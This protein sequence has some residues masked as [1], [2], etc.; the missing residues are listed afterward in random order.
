MKNIYFFIQ[1]LARR[2]SCHMKVTDCCIKSN[3]LGFLAFSFIWIN[4]SLK[5]EVTLNDVVEVKWRKEAYRGG[6][7]AGDGQ[8][9]GVLTGIR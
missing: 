5:V 4:T 2:F 8:M 7:V 1:S 6:S 9:G 3:V